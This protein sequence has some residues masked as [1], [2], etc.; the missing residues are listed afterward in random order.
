[1]SSIQDAADLKRRKE[2][3]VT[4]H[5]GSSIADLRDVTLAGI[6]CNAAWIF[7]VS[8]NPWLKHSFWL[9]F[10][11]NWLSLLFSVTIFG[12]QP[13]LTCMI[14]LSALGVLTNAPKGM[15]KQKEEKRN[16]GQSATLTVYRSTMLILTS[17]AILAVDFPIFPRKYAKVE[18][19]GISLMDL[20]VGSFVF[21]NGIISYRRFK[22]SSQL[23]RLARIRESLRSTLILLVLGLIR[24]FSVKATNYQEH[25]TEYGVH[26]NFF[27]TL[28]LLP[29]VSIAFDF[30]S[31][32]LRF[33]LG[34]IGALVYEYYLMS[35]PTFL[36][37]LLNAERTDFISA[38]REGIFSFVGYCIIYLCG[39][40]VGSII[41]SN[42]DTMQT[43][44]RLLRYTIL[45]FLI[46][47]FL[48]NNHPLQ[49]S[50]RFASLGYS[51]V[52]TTFNLLIL[53]CYH[54]IVEC[55]AG[56][57]FVSD[58][59]VA[60]NKNGMAMFLVSNVS[61]GMINFT[62]NTIDSSPSKSMTIL[63]VYALFLAIFALKVPFKLKL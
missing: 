23:S 1:M 59:Y 47:Y 44:W 61:T 38:N 43:L 54:I 50:R 62:F 58:T 32:K 60:V 49:I 37:Y 13:L 9:D 25:V 16:D 4:G 42:S 57:A 27:F 40:Q 5:S 7:I 34:L 12:E 3:F 63:I 2:E 46:S 39:Q 20:G 53:T 11:L 8:R 36:D 45:S 15:P 55:F 29:L 24:L 22:K 35:S 26:W 33:A 17:F 51:S 10:S 31:M 41:F 30:L 56:G 18:T 52:V 6:L 48:I 19:W 28:S 21:S 14:A